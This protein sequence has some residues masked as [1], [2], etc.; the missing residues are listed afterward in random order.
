MRAVICA[1]AKC[2]NKYINNWCKY[3]LDLGFDHIYIYDNNDSSYPR[4]DKCITKDIMSKVTFFNVRDIHKQA[5]QDEVYTKFY[6]N[7]KD[8]FDWCAYID[9][10]EF[11]ELR[12][13]LNIKEFLAQDK[14]KDF[15]VIRLKWHLYGDD[16]YIE[17]DESIPVQK[18]FKKHLTNAKKSNQCKSI[19]RGALENIAFHSSHYPS[20]YHP[21]ANS[22]KKLIQCMPDGSATQTSISCWQNF[23]DSAWI[24]HYMTKTLKEFLDQKLGRTDCQFK[25]ASLNLDYYWSL[26]KKTPEK[27]AYI[28]KYLQDKQ[29]RTTAPVK[30]RFFTTISKLKRY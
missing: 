13:H 6:N 8:T 29:E 2:E 11:I 18:F 24:N 27:L 9:I 23:D 15:E 28:E 20:Q 7:Y 25:K 22:Y 3:H 17:R 26:N 30:N 14:F 21:A 10:D 16:G 12:D 4:V 1:I 5:F 19:I